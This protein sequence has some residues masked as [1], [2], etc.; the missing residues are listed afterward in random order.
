MIGARALI[1]QM[2]NVGYTFNVSLSWGAKKPQKIKPSDPQI[3]VKPIYIIILWLLR[4]VCMYVVRTK[5]PVLAMLRKNMQK[6]AK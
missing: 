1:G 3:L 2:I 5:T 6:Y 4:C